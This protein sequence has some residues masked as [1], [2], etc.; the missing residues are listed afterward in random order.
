VGDGLANWPYD[1]DM[2]HTAALPRLKIQLF[3]LKSSESSRS[4]GG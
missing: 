2:I 1:E 4:C 3:V